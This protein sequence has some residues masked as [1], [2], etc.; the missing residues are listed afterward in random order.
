MYARILKTF[1][2]QYLVA[3]SC[4]K[5]RSSGTVQVSDEKNGEVFKRARKYCIKKT[6]YTTF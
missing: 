5:W 6:T 3:Y 1:S 4:K 2:R